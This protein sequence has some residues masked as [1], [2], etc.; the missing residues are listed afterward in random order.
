MSL[1]SDNL[2]DHASAVSCRICGNATEN[3]SEI[4]DQHGA[5]NWKTLTQIE[6]EFQASTARRLRRISIAFVS[7]LKVMPS[8]EKVS[9]VEVSPPVHAQRLLDW[10]I[11]PKRRK[12][13][14]GDLDELFSIILK[15]DGGRAAKS[16]YWWQVIRSSAETWRWFGLVGL[17]AWIIKKFTG[18]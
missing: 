18:T 8:Q 17:L 6:K 16:W 7:R 9:T 14:R 4:C 13:V 3:T 10:L 1:G 5:Q 2:H 11:H 12:E 15:R